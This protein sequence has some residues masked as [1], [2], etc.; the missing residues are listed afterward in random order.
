MS[1]R[2]FILLSVAAVLAICAAF[3]LA[4]KRNQAPDA[5]DTL[6]L[7]TLASELN[8]VNGLSVRKGS[9]ANSVTLHQVA[10]QWSVAERGDY[11]ADVPKLRKL[12]LDLVDLKI[13]EAKTS[14]PASFAVIGVED[15]SQTGATGA[16]ITVTTPQL[17]HSVIVGKAVGQGSFARRSGENQSYI[18]QPALS[19]GADP[20][21]WIDSR[22]ID[23]AST[24][25]QSIAVKPAAGAGYTLQRLPGDAGFS[26][27]AVPAGR[28][29]LD[30]KALAPSPTLLSG[31]TTEDVAAA[32]GIDLGK[33]EQAIITQADGNV[34]TVTG[35]TVGDKR[36]IEV[37]STKDAAL[38]AKAQ[39]R[40]FEVATYRY[41]AVFRPVEQ[42][43][44]P[45][46]V[47][48]PQSAAKP[49]NP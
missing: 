3:Y 15:P 6:L 10:G 8:S 46:P 12:L 19:F 14:N 49:H 39:G 18:V 1:P 45:K 9:A 7:P 30:A 21:S 48:V 37:S 32:S 25:I 20:R 16:E 41:D 22:L 34:L 4:T 33:S 42:L 36:W 40:A 31:F 47:P 28:K 29:P 23:I 38:N 13:V 5:G 27:D 44:I 43:L 35:V 24:T 17:K 11:P 26:L 2:R